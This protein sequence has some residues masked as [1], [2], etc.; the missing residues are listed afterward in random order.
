M[1]Q[2]FECF[3]S[4]V[5]LPPL[6]LLIEFAVVLEGCRHGCLWAGG[7]EVMVVFLPGIHRPR[8]SIVERILYWTCREWCSSAALCI[9]CIQCQIR[10][11]THLHRNM[12]TCRIHCTI[13]QYLL[14][15]VLNGVVNLLNFA[16]Y[17]GGIWTWL[18]P[19]LWANWPSVLLHRFWPSITHWQT[20]WNLG[21][22]YCTSSQCPF[23]G[24]WSVKRG[25]REK[26]PGPHPHTEFWWWKTTYIQ[27]HK[28]NHVYK[29]IKH[30][31]RT[32]TVGLLLTD[33]RYPQ[34]LQSVSRDGKQLEEYQLD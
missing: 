30:I 16:L 32:I 25:S 27:R 11:S 9:S 4:R 2:L 26:P 12:Y 17:L 33:H 24:P 20:Q 21:S 19:C 22:S 1:L 23:R 31:T 13:V 34:L 10:L 5:K 15:S 18:L 7:S 8:A 14:P 29:S 6:H 3:E 28:H